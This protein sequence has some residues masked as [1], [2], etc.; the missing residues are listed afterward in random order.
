MSGPAAGLEPK[1]LIDADS[2]Q[3]RVGELA[4]EISRD[5]RDRSPVLVGVLKG[6]YIFLADLTRRLTIPHTV[7]FMAL[8]AYGHRGARR[9]E[10]DVRMDLRDDVA[11]RDVLIV[12][13]IVDSGHTLG[14]LLAI[15]EARRPASLRTCAL[16]RKPACLAVDV[17]IHYVGFDLPD[18]WVVGYGLDYAEQY[19]SLPYLAAISPP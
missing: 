9:G 12:E 14:R 7:E 16:V 1:L 6:A 19:R 10:L 18:V 11:G 13:D 2:I 4:V 5:Y 15:L 17:A 8:S 3:H